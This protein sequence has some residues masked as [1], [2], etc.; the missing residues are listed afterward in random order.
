MSDQLAKIQQAQLALEKAAEALEVESTS[1]NTA[2]K[3]APLD[4][5][6]EMLNGEFYSSCAP[7]TTDR[8]SCYDCCT[9]SKRK[10]QEACP[11]GDYD[12]KVLCRD[13]DGGPKRVCDRSCEAAFDN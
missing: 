4:K 9:S 3:N 5:L 2:S 7:T 8:N 11:E 1:G 6:G 12:C 10:C 13:P